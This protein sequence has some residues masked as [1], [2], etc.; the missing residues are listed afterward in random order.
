ML[1]YHKNQLPSTK[2]PDDLHRTTQSLFD[3]LCVR[4]GNFDYN[5]TESNVGNFKNL[6]NF[7]EPS[8]GKGYWLTALLPNIRPLHPLNK[9]SRGFHAIFGAKNY[10]NEI[11]V[12]IVT[13]F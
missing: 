6:A 1:K 5:D 9:M 10:V 7:G 2:K 3:G 12:G 8:Q 11:I 4:I 13:L